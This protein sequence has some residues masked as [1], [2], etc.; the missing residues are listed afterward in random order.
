MKG[1]FFLMLSTT[2]TNG[3]YHEHHMC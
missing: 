2:R 3:A 1:G